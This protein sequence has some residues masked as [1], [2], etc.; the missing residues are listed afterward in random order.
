MIV[1]WYD[2]FN[3]ALSVLEG[4][5]GR[6]QDNKSAAFTVEQLE[7]AKAAVAKLR[8]FHG[9]PVTKAQMESLRG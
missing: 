4:V 7:D 9:L 3:L 5:L 8:Q 1:N 2:I 6:V